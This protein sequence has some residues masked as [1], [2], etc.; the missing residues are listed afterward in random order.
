[1]AYHLRKAFSKLG[2]NSRRELAA[3]LPRSGP[4]PVP[5]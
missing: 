5:A 2:I 1:M 3:V 4:E